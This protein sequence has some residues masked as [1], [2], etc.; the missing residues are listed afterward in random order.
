MTKNTVDSEIPDS[1]PDKLYK[2]IAWIMAFLALLI[3]LFFLYGQYVIQ[4]PS[5]YDPVCVTYDGPWTHTDSTGYTDTGTAP[6]AFDITGQSEVRVSTV[7]PDD[8]SPEY[9]MFYKAGKNI[10]VEID[11]EVRA[12]FPIGRSAFGVNVKSMWLPIKLYPYDSGKT[13]TIIRD[14]M[15]EESIVVSSGYIGNIYGFFQILLTNNMLILLLAFSILVF[16]ALVVAVC[17]FF[18]IRTR[19]SFALMYLSIA[20]YVSALWLL[21]DNLTY[22]FL[23]NNYHVDGLVEFLIVMLLPYPFMSYLNIL[24]KRRYQK[25]YNVAGI[26]MLLEFVIFT[27]LQFTDVLDFST[28]LPLINLNT[29]IMVILTVGVLLYDLLAKKNHEYLIGG[30]AFLA[31]IPMAVTEVLHV[32]VPGHTNDGF[33]IA[34]GLILLLMLSIYQEVVRIRRMRRETTE[35]Q[36]SNAAK[37]VFLANMSHEIRTPINAILGMN[38]MILRED[39]SDPVR[40]YAESVR[41]ASNALLD[42]INDILDFSKVEQGKL[43]LV[44][45][46]YDIGELLN[47]VITMIRVKSGEKNLELITEVSENIP[48]KLYGD[49]KRIREILINLLNNAV[50]YTPKGSIT[51]KVTMDTA[52]QPPLLTFSVK[53]TGIGIR[54]EDRDKLFKQFERLDYNKNRNIEGTGLG[55]AITASYVRLMGGSIN[56]ISEYGKGSEFVAVIPQDIIDDTPVG[57]ISELSPSGKKETNRMDTFTCPNASLLVVDDNLINQKVAVHLLQISEANVECCSSGPE[58]LDLICRKKYDMIFL[59]HMMP[60]MDGLEALAHAE[61]LP[62]NLN[63]LTP[64]IA[65]TA[66]AIVGAKELYLEHGFTDYLSKPISTA[67]LAEVLLTYLPAD[68]IRKK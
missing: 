38:E 18:R 64:Y 39:I 35:A 36:A 27:T 45:E 25:I 41:D 9:Y 54:E 62:D 66:N 48:R 22:P 3:F 43:E 17:I 52:A 40:E 16:D 6:V 4:N 44:P 21:F 37:S 31:F 55:L 7:L 1:N 29:G 60:D 57:N 68:K 51:L 8:I 42:I 63:Q 59:D 2:S 13:L 58:M 23:F 33:Y 47:S 12:E 15:N 49:P 46:E 10:R 26:E 67:D 56:C 24:Q 32:S 50:K 11:G 20:V 19:R 65:L 28:A 53:D 30:I 5:Y 61:E 14:G 34:V